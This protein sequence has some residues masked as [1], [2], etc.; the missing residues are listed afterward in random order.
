MANPSFFA[1]NLPQPFKIFEEIY[2]IGVLNLN[3]M[4]IKPLTMVLCLAALSTK[5]Q[6]PAGKTVIS[7]LYIYDLEK[8]SAQCIL[9]EERHF[10][11]PNWSRDG[12]YLLINSKGKLEKIGLKGEKLGPMDTGY[13]NKC[14]N[15]HGF[16]FDGKTLFISSSDPEGKI[17]GGSLIYVMDVE[18][19]KSQRLTD[20]APSYWHG[21]S[22]NGQTMV[23]TAERNKNFDIYAMS[24][25]G[26]PEQRL[27]QDEGLDDG[28]EYSPDGRYI[29]FNAYRKGKMQLWRMRPD[30]SQQEQLTFDVHSNWFAHP[31]PSLA[32]AVYIAYMEDQTDK[33]P[34]GRQVKLRL[35]HTDDLRTEDLTPAFYGGQGTI[36]VPSWSPDGRYFAYVQYALK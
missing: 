2:L 14:N 9:S 20:L 7:Q 19:G 16:S 23:Y 28:P 18:S 31:H 27:N 24:S 6:V 29:Y 17:P 32:L 4:N 30:G 34:F 10:E 15:D 26:G 11:A 33:H 3:P 5:A 25:Q 36:N 22:P 8:R 13:I 35:L 21:V 12:S 1:L